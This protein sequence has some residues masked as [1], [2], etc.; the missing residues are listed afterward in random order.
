MNTLKP[1]SAIAAI[2]VLVGCNGVPPVSLLENSTSQQ[3]MLELL[4]DGNETLIIYPQEQGLPELRLNQGKSAKFTFVVIELVK[5]KKREDNGRYRREPGSE[6]LVFG[7]ISPQGYLVQTDLDAT[8]K[9]GSD[10][11]EYSTHR[12]TVNDCP[13]NGWK[14][15]R[16]KSTMHKISAFDRKRTLIEER[17]CP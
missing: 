8:L 10:G 17:I 7:N 12:F 5:I 4:N 3:Q 15:Y 16:I 1:V 6:L 2:L 9:I 13:G 11:K 14:D